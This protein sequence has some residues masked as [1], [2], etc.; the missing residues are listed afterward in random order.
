[1]FCLQVD[2]EVH[3]AEQLMKAAKASEKK[4]T[5]SLQQLHTAKGALHLELLK[6]LLVLEGAYDFKITICFKYHA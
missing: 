6:I 5:M 3:A 1:M 4:V 2:Q